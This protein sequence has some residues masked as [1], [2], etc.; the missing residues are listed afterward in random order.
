MT[1]MRRGET[2]SFVVWVR[3]REGVRRQVWRGGY[4]L[5]RDAV[6][7]ERRFLVEFEDRARE[8]KPPSGPTVQE[9]LEDW[10]V[11]SSP[12][13]RPTTS[14]SYERC[15]RD[16]VLPHLG[17]VILTELGPEHVRNW[18]AELL[19]TPRR[20]RDG[21]LSPTTVGY[22]HR[23]LR[24]ALQDALRWGI[25]DRNPCDA[26]VPPRRAET[27]MRIWTPAEVQRFLAFV[28][29]DPLC[30]MWRLFVVTG[31]RRGEVA[32]LRWIDVDLEAGR[33]AVQHTRVLVYDRP[34]VSRPKTP[35]SRRVLALDAGTVDA[36]RR[37][38]QRQDA[39]RARLAEIWIESGYVFVREDGAPLDPDRIS[40]LFSLIV[41]ATGLTKV[42]L[43]DL[44]HTAA[45]LAMA[46][47]V[48]P[49]V[50]SERLGHASVA[51]TPDVYSHLVPGMQEDAAV[52]IAS[53]V[54]RPL[55]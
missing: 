4:R 16:Y 25:V 19:C 33:I 3:G 31:M 9:F 27:E 53:L 14:C 6:A 30:A 49:K 1:V 18:E 52:Q 8:P 2:W 28:A 47:G 11:Q 50:V 21:A 38:R 17:D 29:D 48:H 42:R 13:R 22:C 55:H 35:R 24:R 32:G 51:F 12:T 34:E 54:D 44:R 40:H 45:S 46:S 43:H 36:L 23:L 5:K 15:I 7:A 41:A 20:F 26:V 10:L 37:H 39:E